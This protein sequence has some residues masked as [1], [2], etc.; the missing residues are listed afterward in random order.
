MITRLP[1]NVG[2]PTVSAAVIAGDVVY[3]SHHAGGFDQQ[4]PA[5]QARAALAAMAQTLARVGG[6]M[7]DVVQ[8]RLYLR[9]V[10]H[11]RAACDVFPEFFGDAAPARM[12]VT[13]DFWDSACL[14]QVEGVAVLQ[15]KAGLS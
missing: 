15:G 12:T 6:T 9:D 13:T 2:D 3:L 7:A 8:V 1:T 5:H 4:D 14:V 11:L 10:S